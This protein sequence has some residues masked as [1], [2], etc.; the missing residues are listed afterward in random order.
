MGAGRRSSLRPSCWPGGRAEEGHD[1]RGVGRGGGG[2]RA[3]RMTT[4]LSRPPRGMLDRALRFQYGSSRAATAGPA[5]GSKGGAPSTL[6]WP[7]SSWPMRNRRTSAGSRG[8]CS[9]QIAVVPLA[10]E[11][12]RH[13]VPPADDGTLC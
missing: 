12:L 8:G 1:G 5:A 4:R 13:A 6:P 2:T 9:V 7:L 10:E 11:R 3:S